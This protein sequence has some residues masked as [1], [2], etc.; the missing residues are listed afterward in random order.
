MRNIL[1]RKILSLTLAAIFALGNF[2]AGALPVFADG[3]EKSDI[4]KLR[5]RVENLCNLSQPASNLA[6][7]HIPD[8]IHFRDIE[9]NL[10]N[11]GPS[12]APLR[13]RSTVSL[14]S[15][16]P[17]SAG[18]FSRETNRWNASRCLRVITDWHSFRVR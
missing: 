13:M 17:E 12:A 4:E 9:R 6:P 18:T 15:A 2:G 5:E 16:W 8:N 1:N 14:P 3:E 10:V 7:G 11:G